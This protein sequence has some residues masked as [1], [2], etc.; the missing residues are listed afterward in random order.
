MREGMPIQNKNSENSENNESVLEVPQNNQKI[1]FDYIARLKQK[2]RS[3]VHVFEREAGF[4]IHR[5]TEQRLG[6][7]L[8]ADYVSFLRQHNGVLFFQGH[9][10]LLAF[11]EISFVSSKH[12]AMFVI[13]QGKL[14]TWA[15]VVEGLPTE[16]YTPEFRDLPL[17]EKVKRRRSIAR[18]IDPTELRYVY[19]IWDGEQFTP[20][21]DSF[22]GWLLST[23]QVLDEKC[24]DLHT[25]LSIRLEHDSTSPFVLSLLA[26]ISQLQATR[27]QSTSLSGSSEI[28]LGQTQDNLCSMYDAC[29]ELYP[30]W[31]KMLCRKADLIDAKQPEVAQKLRMESFCHLQ[32][33]VVYLDL[34]PQEPNCVDQLFVYQGNLEEKKQLIEI[35]ESFWEYRIFDVRNHQEFELVHRIVIQLAQFYKTSTNKHRGCDILQK[36]IQLVPNWSYQQSFPEI[37]ILLAEFLID[38]GD[39]DKAEE[40]LQ[41][42]I[43]PPEHQQPFLYNYRAVALL[44]CAQIATYRQEPWCTY[45]FEEIESITTKEDVIGRFCT[46]YDILAHLYLLKAEYRASQSREDHLEEAIAFYKTSISYA[47]EAPQKNHFIE[48]SAYLGLG[49]IFV[50]QQK[51]GM[52]P[53]YYEKVQDILKEHPNEILTARMFL[54]RGFLELYTGQEEKSRQSYQLAIDTF[55]MLHMPLQK[56]WSLLRLAQAGSKLGKTISEE[57][58]SMALRAQTLFYQLACPTGVSAVDRFLDQPQQSLAWHMKTAHELQ[59]KLTR[60]RRCI[61]PYVRSDGERFE[62]KLGAHRISIARCDEKII[63]DLISEIREQA[64]ILGD[65]YVSDVH[66]ALMCFTTATEFLATN[67]SYEAARAMVDLM[68]EIP[69]TGS[70][71]IAFRNTLARTINMNVVEHLLEELSKFDNQVQNKRM[72]LFAAEILGFRREKDSIPHLISMLQSEFLQQDHHLKIAAILA[73]GRIGVTTYTNE[74]HNIDVIDVLYSYLEKLENLT[75]SDMS[76]V[77][78]TIHMVQNDHENTAKKEEKQEEKQEEIQEN[79]QEE[80]KNNCVD[81]KNV[82]NEQEGKQSQQEALALALLLLG[83]RKGLDTLAQMIEGKQFLLTRLFGEM[84]GRFGD[85]SY[86][87]MLQKAALQEG[88]IGMGA[89]VGLGFLGNPRAIPLLLENLVHLNPQIVHLSAHALELITG[90]HENLDD[91]RLRRRW[92]DWWEDNKMNFESGLRYRYGNLFGPEI[93]ISCLRHDSLL[94]RQHSYDELVIATGVKMHFDYDGPFQIQQRQIQKWENWWEENKEDFPSGRWFFQGK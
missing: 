56:A 64:Q 93:L 76:A 19:G 5:V 10:Q 9:L 44:Q 72:L 42:I 26:D 65:T 82:V 51:I 67:K 28:I 85:S 73:L 48:G 45:L 43:H 66:V 12:P 41:S 33:P 59:K 62:R 23:L 39:H 15:V 52:V 29:L 57:D 37:S 24:E 71:H 54:R 55:D 8:E 14:D 91:S 75:I 4:G 94:I 3:Y 17:E 88:I 21:H 60:T 34:L 58:R 38:F 16:M 81:M 63:P 18:D 7:P 32:F 27:L 11:E 35:M 92:L 89:L 84:V 70:V 47:Q 30:T 74:H 20:L 78:K 87:M 2:Y 53:Q 49:E 80:T 61:A 22:T 13:A 40:V 1:I 25:E 83:E 68:K 6:F 69:E 36:F 77:S 90:H 46:G 86:F 79:K 31:P 50:R